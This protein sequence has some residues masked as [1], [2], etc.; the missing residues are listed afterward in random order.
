MFVLFW[1]WPVFLCIC[2][3]VLCAVYS[4]GLFA[5]VVCVVCVV[6]VECVVCCVL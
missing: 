2:L 4:L 6:C 3:S 1:E 5:C